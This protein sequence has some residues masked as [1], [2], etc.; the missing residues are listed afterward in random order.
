MCFQLNLISLDLSSFIDFCF[1]HCQVLGGN[2]NEF[3]A[4]REPAGSFPGWRR[5][6]EKRR[7]FAY[8]TVPGY[9]WLCEWEARA[10]GVLIKH[11]WI[12]KQQQRAEDSVRA[13]WPPC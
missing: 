1:Y 12:Y 10:H 5:A 13:E 7:A 9:I 6:L 2:A 4:L 3:P 11:V 8:I